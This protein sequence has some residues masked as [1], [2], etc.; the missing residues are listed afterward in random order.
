M[1]DLFDKTLFWLRVHLSYH[2][3][4][5]LFT[6]LAALGLVACIRYV[7]RLTGRDSTEDLGSL[8]GTMVNLSR[9]ALIAMATGA[10]QEHFFGYRSE[11][12]ARASIRDDIYDALVTTLLFAA[13]GFVVFFR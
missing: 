11:C 7:G 13:L 3:E 2:R 8:V 4:L 1:R 5:Y 12:P 10:I 6:P 9:V